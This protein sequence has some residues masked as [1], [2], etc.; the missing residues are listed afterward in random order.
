MEAKHEHTL[1]LIWKLKLKLIGKTHFIKLRS[2]PLDPKK[3][4]PLHICS[5]RPW[6][7][8]K[9]VSP[10]PCH[11][12]HTVCHL[13]SFQTLWCLHG[14]PLPRGRGHT[15][16][17]VPRGSL[18]GNLGPLLSLYTVF[19]I[20]MFCFWIRRATLSIIWS[21]FHLWGHAQHGN[22]IPHSPYT[23]T[24]IFT[25]KLLCKFYL[26]FYSDSIIRL[27]VAARVFEAQNLGLQY[28]FRSWES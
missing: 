25:F 11:L 12:I 19:V 3:E 28:C 8:T 6:N 24:T 27:I 26:V 7:V 18:Y 23:P 9:T 1:V 16:P 20:I 22:G 17:A 4:S 14:P 5:L 2:K 13:S 15:L 21:R 10:I